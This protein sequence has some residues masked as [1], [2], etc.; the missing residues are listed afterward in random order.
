MLKIYN[1]NQSKSKRL[2]HFLPGNSFTPCT[3]QK[4]L[5][6]LSDN[7][8]I[9]ISL[10]RPLWDKN[11]IPDFKNWDIFLNDYMESI[12]NENN[13]VGIGH[14]IGGNLLLKAAI[15]NPKKFD[16]I[17][18]LDPT[19]FTPSKI[20]G[21]KIISFFNA[22]SHF[23]SYIKSAENKKM[24]Y[25]SIK[26]MFSSYRKRK[27]F[28]KF[29]DED[30]NLL[31]KSLVIDSNNKVNLIFNNKWDAAIYKTA[32]M[33][34]MFIWNNISRL[35][36]KTLIVRADNS[37]VFYNRTSKLVLKKNNIINIKTI[38]NSDHLF[39]INNSQNTLKFINDYI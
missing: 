23:N 18:L 3:Y 33:N 16:K 12:E 10:L 4:M 1:Q 15:L 14:S 31:I 25:K 7:F 11:P 27:V 36:T 30:L 35:S 13:I 32:L 8:L 38:K 34:D 21:W 37:D 17:I 24:E 2:L 20:S 28:S 9:K 39:P 22:Q 6:G 26:E 5:N 19:F 29:S